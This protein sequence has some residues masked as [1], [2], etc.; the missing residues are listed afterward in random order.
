[1]NEQVLNTDKSQ[2][3]MMPLIKHMCTEIRVNLNS[4][5]PDPSYVC[6]S[7]MTSAAEKRILVSPDGMERMS[8]SRKK[9]CQVPR[10]PDQRIGSPRPNT[11]DLPS[12]RQGKDD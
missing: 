4:P 2:R 10:Y 3:M 11:Q 7:K 6:D 9:A 1:M 8:E 12:W 5:N